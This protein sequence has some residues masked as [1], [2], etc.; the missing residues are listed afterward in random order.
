MIGDPIR[1][2]CVSFREASA[3]G[4]ITGP[5]RSLWA[6]GILA[7]FFWAVLA[8]LCFAAGA[9]K[10]QFVLHKTDGTDAAG[11]LDE[12]ESDWS[13]R[14][15]GDHP[16]RAGVD[17]WATLR[18]LNVPLPSLSFQG[19]QLLFANGD[20]LAAKVLETAGG[21]LGFQ[22]ESAPNK[23]LQVS[24]AALS[25]IWMKPPEN[26]ESLECWR[27][28]RATEKRPRDKVWL[29]NGDEAEGILK[30]IDAGKVLLEVNHKTLEIRRDQV[31]V[32]GLSTEL[33][34]L[35]RPKTPYACAVMK[36]GT[37]LSLSKAMCSDGMNVS[38]TTLFGEPVSI[39]LDEILALYLYQA[40]AVYLSDVKPG[41]YDFASY[42]S[43]SRWGYV[44]DGCVLGHDIYLDGSM[45][46]KG[47]G[48]HSRS[49]LTYD[50]RGNYRRFEALIGLDEKSGR[51]G[52]A[53][54][55][56]LVDGKPKDLGRSGEL[57]GLSK[58]YFVSMELSGAKKLTLIVDFG[59]R[60]SVQSH[61]DWADA[62]LIK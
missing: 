19:E 29:A 16:T 50:L 58:P 41:E 1:A 27:W 30:A 13:L 31:T 37:R 57:T 54:I 4:S 21:R 17:D 12:L 47:L 35:L 62:R 18:R 61:V 23:P 34:A 20:R 51:E 9:D 28:Q 14:L 7:A 44:K 56:I 60:G 25:L 15:G 26:L 49:R 33:A 48:M 52:T 46:S 8:S 2:A 45:F 5:G 22:L 55:K 36:N 40:R 53:H 59:K 39:P 42:L 10:A 43:G 24:L 6:K 32:I 3:Y 11:K 38:A